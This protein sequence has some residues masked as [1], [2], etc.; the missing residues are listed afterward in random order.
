[1]WDRD[2]VLNKVVIESLPEKMAFGLQ[3]K[4]G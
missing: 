3:R 1:M 2:A 4:E